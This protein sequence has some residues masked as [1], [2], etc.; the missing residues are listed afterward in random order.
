M[1]YKRPIIF[2]LMSSLLNLMVFNLSGCGSQSTKPEATQ[3][4][5]S[6]A[7]E[8]YQIGDF[9]SAAEA[10]LLL[11][12]SYPRDKFKH[13]LAA[14]DML[15]R[16]HQLEK[17]EQLIVLLP[18]KKLTNIQ[19][20]LKNIYSA[21]ILLAKDM[22]EEA[23]EKLNF[24]LPVE[25]PRSVLAQLYATRTIMLEQ[26]KQYLAAA[27][28]RILLNTYLDKNSEILDN[29]NRLW[30]V[31]SHIPLD[32]IDTYLSDGVGTLGSW[33]ELAIINKNMLLDKQGFALTIATWQ[34]RYPDHPALH[35][36]VPSMMDDLKKLTIH[37]PKQIALLLPFDSIYRSASIAIREGFM[38][39]W[40]ESRTDQPIIKIYNT[41]IDNI[42]EIY[43]QAITEGADFVVGPLQKQAVSKLVENSEMT[44][45][46]LLLN[47]YDGTKN[48]SPD[49]ANIITLPT[50]M[51]F[52]ISPEEE[53]EQVAERAWFDGH[54]H[55]ITIQTQGSLNQRINNAFTESWQS[56]GGVVL[57][58]AEIDED[59]KD[60]MYTVKRIFSV[61]QSEQ[62]NKSLFNR[63]NRSLKTK[64]RRRKDIDVIFLAVPPTTARRLVPELR[65]YQTSD[66]V[67]Y[68][69]SNIYTGDI[70]P[71]KDK[72]INGVLF[73][74]IPWITDIENK[75]SSLNRAIERHQK[76]SQATNHKRLYAFGIDAYQLIPHISK[77][78]LQ[79][80]HVY[81]GKIGSIKFNKKGQL[82]RTLNWG[83]FV[84]GEAKLYD[85]TSL[86]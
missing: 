62:R 76:S 10:Y 41:N 86:N 33:L 29:Y 73:T 43:E 47:R 51:Q 80:T 39:A 69:T 84:D 28:N 81:S 46:T 54:A 50:F 3:Q 34:Q 66:I 32:E 63:L 2:L 9:R 75:Y 20:I 44:V 65:R 24:S 11:M 8:L 5:D 53:A 31:L 27:K 45:K 38:A 74:E 6:L 13:Q 68:A 42:I 1:R 14:I 82:S 12:Q 36:I 61:H 18:P 55:A 72:D 78:I 52:Y 58:H 7:K 59:P 60:I 15:V 49:E 64:E 71:R 21:Q 16:D 23:Y 70:D 26:R 22:T 77:L 79:P 35:A 30:W 40:Y 67:F 37:P 85:A 4:V 17:A 57:K 83:Q 25:L 56:F 48:L 19:N